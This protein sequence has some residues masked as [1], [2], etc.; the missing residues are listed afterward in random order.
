MC[1]SWSVLVVVSSMP[2]LPFVHDNVPGRLNRGVTRGSYSA[3]LNRIAAQPARVDKADGSS[4]GRVMAALSH[5][6]VIDVT[7]ADQS[8]V[9]AGCRI[10]GNHVKMTWQRAT[11]SGLECAIPRWVTCSREFIG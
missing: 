1:R 9:K 5:A 3:P 4:S 6:A 2:C 8:R 7:A 10:R 11:F